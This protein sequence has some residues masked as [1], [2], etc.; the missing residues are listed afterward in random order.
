MTSEQAVHFVIRAGREGAQR[1]AL[2]AG[3]LFGAAGWSVT[4]SLLDDDRNEP[5]SIPHDVDTVIAFGGD[6]T[7]LEAVRIAH[8]RRASGRHQSWEARLPRWF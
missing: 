8:P 1:L 6:G 2:D 3:A 7:F 5:D 4:E